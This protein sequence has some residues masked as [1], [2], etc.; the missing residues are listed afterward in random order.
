MNEKYV[1]AFIFFE[2]FQ[3]WLRFKYEATLIFFDNTNTIAD[4]NNLI[5]KHRP[6][7]TVNDRLSAPGAYLIFEIIFHTL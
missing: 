1:P 4:S 6:A 3:I 2:T 7:D 5:Q